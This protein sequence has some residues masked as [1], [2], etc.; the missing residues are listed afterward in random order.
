ML[1][2]L[3]FNRPQEESRGIDHRYSALLQG[4]N[5]VIISEVQQFNEDVV[6]ELKFLL[7]AVL[8]LSICL[9]NGSHSYCTKD[10]QICVHLLLVVKFWLL[11]YRLAAWL[12]GNK[13][14]RQWL[15]EYFQQW[16]KH[17]ATDKFQLK[18]RFIGSC[19]N[20]EKQRAEEIPRHKNSSCIK[21]HILIGCLLPE[22]DRDLF[23]VLNLFLSAA[24]TEKWLV[25]SKFCVYIYTHTYNAHQRN[26]N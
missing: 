15:C 6:F 3:H 17:I 5:V 21:F 24:L 4:P 14:P 22:G 2:L 10:N 16:K 18:L 13:N 26:K 25:Y 20:W 23:P 19:K 1:H 11:K 8:W 7:H 12:I 9:F